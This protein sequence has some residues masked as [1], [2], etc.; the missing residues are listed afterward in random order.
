MA[1]KVRL[2]KTF[3]KRINSTKQPTG[4]YIE[5]DVNL[6]R[7]TSIMSPT[8]ILSTYD[9]SYNYVYVPSWG[10]YYFVNDVVLGN[11][12]LFELHCTF[13]ALASYKASIGAYTCFVE[14]TSDGTKISPYIRDNA[15]SCEDRVISTE[16]AS[17][18]ALASASVYIVRVLGRGSTNGIGTFCITGNQLQSMFSGVWGDVD[19]DSISDYIKALCNLY[20]N[21]PS[22]YIVGV[23]RSP[24]GITTYQNNG[25]EN[26]TMYVGGHESN[27][28]GIRVDTANAVVFSGRTL[29]KPTNMY[30]DFRATDPAFSQY[31][32]YLPTIGIVPLPAEIMNLELKMTLCA[33]L[34]SGDLTYMLYGAGDLIASYTSNCYASVSVGMQ[35]GSAG[36]SPTVALSAIASGM[37]SQNVLMATSGAIVGMKSIMSP[38]A[39]VLGT[40]G[41]IGATET[42]PDIVISCMQKSSSDIP[43]TVYGRPCEQNLL[44]GG[45][46]GFIK[47]QNASID[48]IAGTSEDKNLVNS[49]LN[50]G[51]YYE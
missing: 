26:Q 12:N 10:R 1:F 15:V 18:S 7:D 4:T 21:D 31:T 47:C 11:T 13:D 33:D 45:I 17:T 9:P 3:V 6:K 40:Q 42:Y 24:I 35:N 22:Q 36:S 23:Y 41:S 2:Y 51:F 49:F 34:F 14:R 29:N 20:I 44:L 8:F 46:S 48:N 25:S 50:N 32:M 19:A 37:A 43:T 38:P 27:L 5:K 30:N 16:S 39:S 28:K